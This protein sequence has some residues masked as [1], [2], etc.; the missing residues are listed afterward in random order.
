[1]VNAAS[2]IENGTEID[3]VKNHVSL[4]SCLQLSLR[5]CLWQMS[6]TRVLA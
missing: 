2:S 5:L 6:D 3:E 1:M 4:F